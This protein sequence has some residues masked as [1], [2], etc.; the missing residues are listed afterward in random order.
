VTSVKAD[1]RSKRRNLSRGVW[2]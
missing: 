2:Q 1:K